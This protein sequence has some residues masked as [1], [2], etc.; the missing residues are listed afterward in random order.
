M[1]E[2]DKKDK[3]ILFAL[4]RNCRQSLNAIAKKTRLSK[5]V[6]RYRIH[7]LEKE[8]YITGYISVIDFTKLGHHIVRLYVKL[9]NTT[10]KIEEEIVNYLMQQ[11]TIIIVYRTDG[12]YELAIG[13]LV[14][15]LRDYQETFEAFLNRYRPYVVDKNFS[16]FHDYLQ[17][18]R[19]Y[20]V[21]EKERDYTELSTG[22]HKLYEYDDTDILILN[23]ISTYARM[24][25]VDLSQKLYIPINT[26]KYRLKNLE[27]NKV[28]VAYRALIDYHK[29]GFDYYKVDFILEDRSI[30]SALQEFVRRN[31]YIIYR[32]SSIGGSDF[33]FDCELPSQAAF[34]ALIEEI[35][36][37]F[38][39]KIRSF[40]YYKAIRIYKYSYFPRLLLN[41]VKKKKK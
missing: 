17:Y 34:Y 11:E 13:F 22:S 30:M 19:N 12:N 38:P 40:F 26:I 27:R 29:F 8:G 28:I 16:V 31:P 33:E 15:D 37:L 35:R 25:L 9:Q 6:V 2:I 7:R 14:K 39:K 21:E 23:E 18:F 10:A 1:I 24:S 32:D 3:E 5:D 20:L 4:D 41:E 36:T